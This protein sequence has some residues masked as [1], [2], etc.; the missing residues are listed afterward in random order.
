VPLRVD[1]NLTLWWVSIWSSTMPFAL[2]VMLLSVV[3][4]RFAPRGVAVGVALA[5]GFGTLL[6]P[7]G[8][9]LY[10]HILSALLGFAAWA[11]VSREPVT[12]RDAA[13]A[14]LLAGGAVTVE[15]ESAI[16]V[17]VLGG[18][19]LLRH[20]HRLVPY[21]LGGLLPVIVLGWYQWRAFGA[22]W[23]TPSEF[24]SGVLNG[25]TE[26]GYSIPS[27]GD[28][29]DLA[30]GSRG[31]WIVAPVV[32]LAAGCAVW[33]ACTGEG[34]VRTHAVVAIVVFGAYLVL[35][36]GW[37]GTPL[38]EEPGPRYLAPALPFL[39]VPLAAAW[40][41]V[42]VAA[43]FLA[44][45]GGLFAFATLWTQILVP[46]GTSLLTANRARVQNH[47]FAPTIWS[48]GFGRFGVLLYGVIVAAAG[49]LLVRCL[50]PRR[51]VA[52]RARR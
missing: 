26:G 36:A 18:Y 39:A 3:A 7:Y 4:E 49:I 31:L 41:R 48:M 29:V 40:E 43:V 52:G 17:A 20:R 51:V 37:S 38:L 10:G 5:L 1:G 19:L 46:Q 27:V 47:D 50:A 28:L 32:L 2:L 13:L 35:C 15:Y 9:N 42:R 22:P 14:G 24:Y 44:I 11:V 23:R 34:A 30:F 33:L 16:I 12:G 25:T 6:L 21:A 8:A 45:V